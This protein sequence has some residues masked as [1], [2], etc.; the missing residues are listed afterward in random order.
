[1]MHHRVPHRLFPDEHPSL[2]R[3]V[4]LVLCDDEWARIDAYRVSPAY[5]RRSGGLFGLWIGT[6]MITPR[7]LSDGLRTHPRHQPGRA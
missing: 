1:M 7:P 6:S 5:K 2:P 4:Q 3:L